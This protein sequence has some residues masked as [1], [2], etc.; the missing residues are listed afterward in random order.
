MKFKERV[1]KE[2]K[3][4]IKTNTEI[5]HLSPAVRKIVIEKK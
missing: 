5:K 1:S 3:N 4:Q 2:K